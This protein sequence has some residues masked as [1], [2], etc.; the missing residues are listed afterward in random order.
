MSARP[1]GKSSAMSA[2]AVEVQ[3]DAI[4]FD[5]EG[6]PIDSLDTADFRRVATR[7]DRNVANLH[8]RDGQRL[9]MSPDPI[10]S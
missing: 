6:M 1:T 10:Q 7:H 3:A 4:W 2:K 9:I 5:M 8:R